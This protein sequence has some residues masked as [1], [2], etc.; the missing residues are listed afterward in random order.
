MANKI[1]IWGH[2]YNGHTHGY[3]HSSYFKAF[4][5]LGYETYWLDDADDVSNMNFD[6]S[7]FLTEGQVQNKI[8]LN[9]NSKYILHHV[10]NGKY[11]DNNLSFINLGNYLK[12]CNAGVSPNYDGFT[13]EK[14]GDLCFIDN[15][16]KC[17][18]QPWATDLLPNEIDINDA[19]KAQDNMKNIF[20]IGTQHDNH[21][22]INIFKEQCISNSFEFNILHN[23]KDEDNKRLTRESA[24]SVDLRGPWHVECGY[25][26]CRIFKNITY[27]RI[28]GT[29]SKHVKEVFGDYVIYDENP[30]TLF[31]LL[32]DSEKN[33]DL[34]KIKDAMLFVKDKHTYYNRIQNILNVI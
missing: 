20:Y 4:K 2:K 5:S 28:T 12:S 13:V 29:N 11:I 14:L 3:I 23:V 1:I 26:P 8:P 33:I 18:Y 22:E 30:N 24:L 9:K 15:D 17:L 27:G 16:N 6:N 25:L 10:N 31:N 19:M 21:R 32:S 7:I 34:L